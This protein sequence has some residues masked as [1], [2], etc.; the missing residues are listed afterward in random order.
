MTGEIDECLICCQR[1]DLFGIGSCLHPA[2]ME[3]SIRMRIFGESNICPQCRSPNETLY[4]VSAPKSWDNFQLP[5]QRVPHA[6]EQKYQIRFES[7]YAVHCYESYMAHNCHVCAKRGDEHSSFPTFAA[8]RQHMGQVHQLS[9]CHICCENLNILTK[10]RKTYTKP[11]LQRHMKEG[12]KGDDGIRGHPTCL[13]CEQRFFDEEQQYRHLR[14]DH[15]FCQICDTDGADNYFYAKPEQL[16]RHYQK[17]HYTCLDRECL[18][19]GIVF[20]SEMEL[21]VHKAKNHATGI[22]SIP[23][24]FQFSNRVPGGQRAGPS[25]GRMD[26]NTSGSAS[27]LPA[28]SGYGRVALVPNPQPNGPSRPDNVVIVPSAQSTNPQ[29]R[30]I[31][32]AYNPAGNEF[33][34]LAP[35]RPYGAPPDWRAE[36]Q[37]MKASKP[38]PISIQS[39]E[40][41]PVLS[42]GSGGSSSS[43]PAANSVWAKGKPTALFKYVPAEQSKEQQ[44]KRKPFIPAPDVWPEHMLEKLKARELGLPDPD[45]VEK[46]EALSAEQ[47]NKKSKKKKSKTVSAN[48]VVNKLDEE[49]VPS[50]SKFDMLGAFDEGAEE[51]DRKANADW[52]TAKVKSDKQKSTADTTTLRPTSDGFVQI[53][54]GNRPITLR[55]IA[56]T[57]RPVDAP[58]ETEREEVARPQVEEK[59]EVQKENQEENT[60]AHK[61][62]TFSNWEEDLS[63]YDLSDPIDSTGGAASGQQFSLSSIANMFYWPFGGAAESNSTASANSKTDKSKKK[64]A[65]STQRQNNNAESSGTFDVI[66][67]QFTEADKPSASVATNEM[68]SSPPPG[69]TANV[70]ENQSDA[71]PGF[72]DSH[73]TDAPPPGFESKFTKPTPSHEV[74]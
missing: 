61:M 26:D 73:A 58:T 51:V 12:D 19:M 48:A 15:Y 53:N 38:A 13:F 41:F 66:E 10:D 6:D 18:E 72:T 27:L 14:K 34:S 52:W 68:S 33:P 23:V 11:E 28:A 59:Q 67:P 63:Y 45:E 49:F 55:S 3:C 71:P 9:F 31:R 60:A 74:D 70:P 30:I 36:V 22:R 8:L 25:R 39:G 54:S 16:Y 46:A 4:F 17:E 32:S 2:C 43:K 40:Q 21:N 5:K 37:Q 1:S 57:V 62:P 20:R 44:P 64:K 47:P 69:F 35:S 56:S 29:P 7:D 50:S 42:G 65:G 24:D